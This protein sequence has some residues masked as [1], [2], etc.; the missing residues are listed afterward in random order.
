[1]RFM[2]S[3]CAVTELDFRGFDPSTLTDLYYAF[4][5][6]SSLETIYADSTWALPTSGISGSQ[7]FYSC[8]TSLVGGAGTV[9]SSAATSYTYF[10]IDTASTPG[11]LTAS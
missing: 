9:R 11:Y 5:G 3:S 10:H 1:M 8:S 4:S 6:C 2:F 7:C